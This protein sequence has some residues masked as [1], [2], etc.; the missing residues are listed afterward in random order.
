M[1]TKRLATH[2]TYSYSI[3]FHTISYY[4]PQHAPISL[5]IFLLSRQTLF[6]LKLFSLFRQF[7]TIWKAEMKSKNAKLFSIAHLCTRKE[8]GTV[9]LFSMVLSI[10]ES[11][12]SSLRW[13]SRTLCLHEETLLLDELDAEPQFTLFFNALQFSGSRYHSQIT[14]TDNLIPLFDILRYSDILIYTSIHLNTLRYSDSI[15]YTS[16]SL[17]S[18]IQTSNTAAILYTLLLPDRL[19]KFGFWFTWKRKSLCLIC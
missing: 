9:C 6:S 5:N 17:D 8:P 15:R 11:S 13:S 10:H 14:L 3:L 4:S 1:L 18:E 16:V 19:R 7:P 12:T 2:S